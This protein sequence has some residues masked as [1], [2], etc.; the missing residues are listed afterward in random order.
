MLKPIVLLLVLGAAAC[1]PVN[2]LRD[3]L[4]PQSPYERY[5]DSLQSVRLHETAVGAAWMA[6]GRQALATTR[7]VKLPHRDVDTVRSETPSAAAYRL[8][9]HRGQIYR[10][11]VSVESAAPLNLFADLFRVSE[12]EEPARVAGF[13]PPARRFDFEP[14]EDGTFVLRIQ[15]ELFGAGHLTVAQNARAALLFPVPGHGRAHV[16]SFFGA[17]RSGGE[18]EHHGI[19]IFAP[20]G[21][22]AVAAADG[23]ITSTSPN[24]LGGNVVWLWDPFRGQTLYYAHL[25]RLAVSRGEWVSRGD[26]VGFVGNTGNARST[27]PHLH[28]GIYRRGS[29]PID[30]L[31]Y[32]VDPRR[33]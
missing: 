1:G 16:Q 12:G 28:F 23:L 13:G 18:R 24:N 9:L 26:A 20:R 33:D 5:V 14:P 30:P 7:T 4:L 27:A 31:R 22:Q 8:D 17:A 19:D 6:T 2:R 21:T 15:A 25:D 3:A 11:A 29:G 32:V 10:L